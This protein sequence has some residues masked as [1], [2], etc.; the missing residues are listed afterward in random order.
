M[1]YF[2][3]SKDG[4][5]LYCLFFAGVLLSFSTIYSRNFRNSKAVPCQRNVVQ[6]IVSDGSS[7]LP[8]VTISLKSNKNSAVITDYNGHYSIE[9]SPRDTLIVSFIGFKTK[10]IPVNDRAKIDIKLEYDT[11]TLQEV[12]VNA[13]YYSVKERDRT[14]SIARITSKDIETQPVTNV[15]ATMQGRMAG[16]NIVQNSGMPGSG[17]SIEIRGLNSLRNDGNT[18]LYIIDGV[19]YS[20]Q[21]IG[22]SYTSGNMSSQ[23]SPLNSI[24]PSDI[25]S[26]EVLKDA[27]AT[28][29][30]GS[31]GANGVVLI[32]TRKGKSGKTSFTASYSNGIGKVTRFKDVLDTPRYLAMRKEA[33]ANDG[34]TQYPASAYDVNGTWDQNRNTNWQKELIGGTA[35]YTNI[36]SSVSGG[37]E[38]TQ[39][40]LSGNYSRE[41]TVFPGNFDYVKAGGHFSASHES[42]DKRFRLNFSAVYAGQFSTLPSVDFTQT[43]AMLAPNAPALYDAA[44]SLNW[45]NNT[46][47]NPLAPL[48]GKTNG[49]TYDLLSN[50]ILT[51]DIGVGFSAGGSFGYTSLNQKQ[52]NLQPNTIYNPAN[53]LGSESSSVFTNKISRSSWIIEPKLSWTKNLGKTAIDA[54]AGTT[55]QQQNAD[56]LINYYKGFSTNSLMENPQSAVTN[57]ILNS[58]ESVYKY[59]AFFTRVN[60]NYDGKYILNLTGRRD[61]SSRFGPGRQFATFG[62]VGAAMIYSGEKWIKDNIPFLSFGK[63]RASYGTSGNDQIGDYQFLDTYSA[64]AARYQGISGLQPSRL[65][66][67][68]FG[69]ETNRKMELALENGFIN[70]RI[71]TSVAWFQNRSSSQLVGIPL[72]GTTGFASI[73]GNLDAEVQNMG[74]EIAIRTV[75]VKSGDFSWTSSFNLTSIRNKLL[76]FPSLEASTYKN[77]YVIGKPLNLVKVFHYTG[78][79]AA[80]SYQFEDVNKDGNLTAVEDKKTIKDLNPKYYGGLQNQFR[81]RGVELDFLFQFVKQENFNENFGNPMP[82][83]MS[84]QPSGVTS[85]WQNAGDMGPYQGYSDSNAARRT[86]NTRYIQ[87]DAAISD[88]SYIRLKNISLSYELPKSWTKSINCRL[89]VEGQ[90]VLTFTKYKGIDPEFKVSGF[91]PPLRIFSTSIQLTF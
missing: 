91:L 46:F 70:D 11:T 6:G 3:F 74:I 36:Q 84:N 55:F 69:W 77:R 25:A 29:I 16:V 30:Y 20:S 18:P 44:G 56:Q 48:N 59:Q 79:D 5:A 60:F 67:P 61:G 86:T 14:G 62:A 26:I 78:L 53:G 71:F 42:E 51:Y 64:S 38:K 58:N 45:E 27:D 83:T 50:A 1:N 57:T 21:S 19:P 7:P 89:S 9:A 2:S 76:S 31:R 15:L 73:Q 81:F 85:H 39:F 8:G 23:N 17:F 43:S 12:R 66:N 82:G 13:G 47:D 68:D 22:S 35:D 75:N 90:N 10:F 34:V 54:L 41:T 28:A 52:Q 88:A 33:F 24:N 80:G 65:F 87:S 37:S 49:N 40:L 72:P 63:I 32:T 4:R